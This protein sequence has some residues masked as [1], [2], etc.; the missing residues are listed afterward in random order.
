M[1]VQRWIDE[2]NLMK[3]LLTGL[4]T[5]SVFMEVQAAPKVEVF[6][7]S[8]FQGLVDGVGEKTM[9][10][11]PTVITMQ[12]NGVL[13]VWDSGNFKWRRVSQS[14][15]VSTADTWNTTGID[16]AVILN[17]L[18]AFSTPGRLLIAQPGAKLNDLEVERSPR[19][20]G[21]LGLAINSKNEILIADAAANRI[22]KFS[23]EQLF[24]LAGSGNPETVDGEGIFSSFNSPRAIAA[25]SLGQIF[26]QQSDSKFRVIDTKG[27]VST[28]SVSFSKPG[29]TIDEF[30]NIWVIQGNSITRIN[31]AS[32][33]PTLSVSAGNS[34]GDLVSNKNGQIYTTDPEGNKVYKVTVNSAPSSTPI[35][36][37]SIQVITELTIRGQSGESYRIESADAIESKWSPLAIVKLQSD[38]HIWREQAQVNRK[39][40]RAILLP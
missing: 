35:H 16:D 38:A 8:N 21:T 13:W 34:V 29:M 24:T 7:G 17:E 27:K 14:R 2:E 30:D 40:Y 39:F 28:V 1:V 9:F 19:F 37:V 22:K 15:E 33:E 11:R 26:V 10:F 23:N 18:S 3:K 6:A 36:P 5:M 4:F 12:P 31:P 25:N 20:G 32:Y